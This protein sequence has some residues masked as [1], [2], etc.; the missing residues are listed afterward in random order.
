VAH[1]T[2]TGSA[3]RTDG[4]DRTDRPD[5]PGEADPVVRAA[6]ALVGGPLGRR[7][8]GTLTGSRGPAVLLALAAVVP[9]ALA[10]LLR[11]HCR[12]TGWASPGQYVHA[13]YSDVPALVGTGAAPGGASG[14]PPT[15]AVVLRL[16]DLATTTP[17]GAFDL[18]VLLAALSLSV[19]AVL[20]VRARSTRG[21]G[22]PWDGALVA[23]SPVVVVAGLVSVDLVGVA[24]LAG[25]L[26][27][28]A[29]RRPAVAGALV[30]LAAGVRPVAVLVLLA[31]WLVVLVGRREHARARRRS[32]DAAEP[33]GPL[34]ALAAT[35]AA[36][37][38]AGLVT[39]ASRVGTG[40]QPGGSRWW[41]GGG[42]AGFGSVWLLPGLQGTLPDGSQVPWGPLPATAVSVLAGVG[43]LVVVLL[44][45]AAAARTVGADPVARLA[46]VSLVLVGGA[47]VV[48]PSVP[49][50]ATLVLLPLAAVAAPRWRDHLL[51]GLAEGA[52]ATGTWLYIYA[53]SS[54]DGRGLSPGGYAVVLVVR[55]LAV[56]WLAA[57]GVRLVGRRSPREPAAVRVETGPGAGPERREQPVA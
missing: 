37:L 23:L 15:T 38:A 52:A 45:A 7:A 16:L 24:L 32:G 11:Q 41:D 20:V 9:V 27:A 55:L 54:E 33:L 57:Q 26:L 18:S 50:Q 14:Q 29:R 43:L 19:A 28:L 22:S 13:C 39:L 8:G 12:A 1:P 42:G 34:E 6:S 31:L 40:T 48:S 44:G 53:T 35:A 56:G 17:R 30:G 2:G 36:V 25:A 49:V 3:E 46:A 21:A 4:A 47:L 51:W 5:R 10:A